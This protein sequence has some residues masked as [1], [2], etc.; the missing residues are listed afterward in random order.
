MGRFGDF[1]RT[2][3][4]VGFLAV[5]LT[6]GVRNARADFTFGQPQN[7]GPNINSS[8]IDAGTNIS[9]DGCTLYFSSNRP[10]GRGGWD[11]W[12]ATRLTTDADWGPPENLGPTVNTPSDDGPGS[13]SADGLSLYFAS[14]R[15][16]G[17]GSYD[18]WVTTRATK[19]GVWGI[20]V[21]LGPTVNSATGDDHPSISADGLSLYFVSNR[22]GG[23]GSQDL[24][25][26]TR[27]TLSDPWGAPVNLGSTVN[28]SNFEEW[29]AIS[30]DG[31]LLFFYSGPGSNSS[32]PHDIW[33]TRRATVSDPW[34][35]ALNMGLGIN[36][37]AS[38]GVPWISADG[39]E[40]YF[41]SWRTGGYGAGDIYVT[42]RSTKNDPWG[43]PVNFGPVVNSAYNEVSA[44]L[45]PDGRVLLFS[46]LLDGTP[47]PGGHG[48][49]DMWMTRRASISAPWEAPVNLGSQ[50]NG[51]AH[52]IIPRISIDGSTLYFTTLTTGTWDN[53][54]ASLIPICDFNG[55]GVVD[56][57]DVCLMVDH[58]GENYPLCDIGPS[59]LGN[60]IVDVQDL[61]VL[62]E[63]LFTDL[64]IF[65]DED[66]PNDAGPGDPLTSDPLEDG[67]AEHPF[68]SIQQ[69]IDA[70]SETDS[71]VVLPGTYTGDGN[72][73]IS[74]RGKRI[75]A[76]SIDPSDSQVVAATVIDCQGTQAERHQG[77]VF[78]RA[79]SAQSVLAGLT[80]TNA[81][82]YYGG[83]ISCTN[84]SSP[85]ISKCVLKGNNAVKGGGGFSNQGG[86][87][88]V[89]NCIFSGN[90]AESGGGL[91]DSSNTLVVNCTFTNN[92][93]T[94]GGGIHN[95]GGA[96]T[97]TNCILWNNTPAEVH[98]GAGT[99]SATYCNIKRGFTGEGNI[100][101]DPLFADAA[102]GDYH[103]KSHGGR[104]NPA[105]E[106]WVIDGITSPCIDAG[107]PS[108][109]VGD[110]P[111]PNGG[112][113][114]MGAYGGTAEASKSVN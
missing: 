4:W 37:S 86:S 93:T 35:Q 10:G 99:I 104:W 58:W 83:G 80:I 33:V 100:A 53:W 17:F 60:G 6:G 113:I 102:N 67:S 111:Q 43:E 90:S 1:K 2:L 81:Y 20:P 48:G 72:R 69:A 46:D 55:D 88:K 22:A 52:E 36:S 38:D 51:S 64:R 97:L 106:T 49:A 65:V 98:I 26:T 44:S 23:S 82:G 16:G 11:L 96:L 89:T 5:V 41:S 8:S 50:V 84:N 7:L 25:V 61:I 108:S 62:S 85:N 27:A 112:R 95:Q 31:L 9:A 54:Q 15:A 68:D 24:W 94:S 57:A 13:I 34:G 63:Y 105:S 32:G 109:P 19:G 74:F 56:A 87:P 76:R 39:L 71:V 66:A 110:E 42:R 77:F 91:Y 12:V 92:S 3:V 103:L 79:E 40:L 14:N 107:D 28:S 45:S 47:R 73:D 59:P 21:N 70:A 18:T 75:T 78:Y 101:A 114:N 30:A 29:P